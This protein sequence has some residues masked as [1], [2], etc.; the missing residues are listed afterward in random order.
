[1][2]EDKASRQIFDQIREDSSS[3]FVLHDSASFISKGTN[4]RTATSKLSLNFDFDAELLQHKIYK[5]ALR[6]LMRRPKD[7]GLL[8]LVAP[9]APHTE[10]D[11]SNTSMPKEFRTLAVGQQ[12]HEMIWSLMPKYTTDAADHTRATIQNAICH[13][14]ALELAR[15]HESTTC[16]CSVNMQDW[17]LAYPIVYEFSNSTMPLR[18]VKMLRQCALTNN[19][20][21]CVNSPLLQ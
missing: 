20:T 1:M 21:H 4:I 14:L 18:F 11:P 9:S 16:T 7:Q 15:E 6:A 8:K 3:L 17:P 19:Q 13:A 10:N 2:V 5:G 12:A